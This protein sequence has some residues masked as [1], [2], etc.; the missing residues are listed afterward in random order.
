[1]YCPINTGLEL[2]TTQNTEREYLLRVS[3]L[4]IYN[5]SLK[6]LLA[7]IPSKG[8]SLPTKDVPRKSMAP[9]PS[10]PTKGGF[11]PSPSSNAIRIVEDQAKGR[12]VLTGIREE[13][14]TS[15]ED[16]LRL[17]EDGQRMRHVGATD[18]NERSSRSH[19]VF[20]ITIESR[21]RAPEGDTSVPSIGSR[22]AAAETR[23]SMLNLIDLAGSE[24]AAT[25][26]ARR[27][28][29][30]FV[31]S[32]DFPVVPTHLVLMLLLRSTNRF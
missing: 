21:G 30:A 16:V 12:I 1:M 28:E 20:Q 17:L 7:A 13:I 23:I 9:R 19:C 2:T 27:K 24:R 4:E 8:T 22:A 31:C 32:S 14:V 25:D 6:D 26:Q 29:G 18:W 10:S 11:T 5:E 3:Y 15:P